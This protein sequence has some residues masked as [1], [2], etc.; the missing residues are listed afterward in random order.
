MNPFE[1]IFNVGMMNRLEETDSLALTSG[2]R[3]WLRTML[4]HPAANDAFTPDTLNKLRAMLKQEAAH[5]SQEI[6]IEKAKSKEKQV[7]HPLIRPCRR[8]IMNN[9]GIR[10]SLRLKHGGTKSNQ[11]GLPIKLEYSMVKREWYLLWYNTRNRALMSTRLSHIISLEEI[12]VPLDR[13]QKLRARVARLLKERQ[14]EAV[15]EIVKSYNEEL[16]RILYAFS[17]FDKK[18]SFDEETEIYRI[19]VTYLG[20]ESEFLL[21]KIRFLGLRVRIVEGEKLKRR[22]RESAAKALARYTL[23]E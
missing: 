7:Y 21:S 22:M 3:A 1:K 11:N 16:S 15:I 18:V 17:C 9:S 19:R 12:A 10:L 20:G 14:E 4:E 23:E 6:I 8:A 5:S 2:E 13:I